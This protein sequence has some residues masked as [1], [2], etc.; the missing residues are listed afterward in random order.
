MNNNTNLFVISAPSGAGKTS[1]LK[2]LIK[3]NKRLNYSISYTTRT[4]RK[5]ETHGQDYF[6]ISTN[7]FNN[8]KNNGEFIEYVNVFGNLYATSKT[9]VR[10]II[11]NNLH[12]ILEI[13]WQGAQQVRESMPECISVFILP[14]SQKALKERLFNRD[15]DTKEIIAQR[16]NEAYEDMTHWNE[17]DYCIINDNFE[18]AAAE[19]EAIFNDEGAISLTDNPALIKKIN[20]ILM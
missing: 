14:P 17:F 7:A 9:Q 16:L 8:L 10:N 4:P 6:F 13:D 5:N 15:T 19:L 3:R 12:A 2:T 11:K 1:L 18:T 20:K